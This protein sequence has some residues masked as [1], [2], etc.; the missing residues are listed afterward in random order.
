MQPKEAAWPGSARLVLGANTKVPGP[1]ERPPS[2]PPTRRSGAAWLTDAYQYASD[3]QNGVALV[4]NKEIVAAFSLN[5][6]PPRAAEGLVRGSAAEPRRLREGR[7]GGQGVRRRQLIVESHPGG[8]RA[9]PTG[10]R[11]TTLTP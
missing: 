5:D 8:R 1:R 7:P 11:G 9:A 4:T 3:Q 10:V 6:P 2:P